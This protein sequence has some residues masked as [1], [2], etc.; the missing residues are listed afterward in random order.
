MCNCINH[1]CIGCDTID[2]N[3]NELKEIPLNVELS[4]SKYKSELQICKDFIIRFESERPNFFWR[5]MTYI[6]FGWKWKHFK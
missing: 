4:I 6:M 3:E 2:N 1:S 5:W